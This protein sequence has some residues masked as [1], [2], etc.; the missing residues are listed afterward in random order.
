MSRINQAVAARQLFIEQ[1]SNGDKAKATFDDI[2]TAHGF[3]VD[4]RIIIEHTGSLQ[5]IFESFD[6][7]RNVIAPLIFEVQNN[8]KLQPR[9]T[10]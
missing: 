6:A 1:A 7:I 8:I 4:L 2:T 3:N 5:G 10:K 9:I